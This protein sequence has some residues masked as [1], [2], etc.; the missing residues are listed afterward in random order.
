MSRALGDLDLK[1]ALRCRAPSASP[2]SD[3][4][5]GPLSSQPF[6]RRVQL[7]EDRR[8]HIALVSDGVTNELGD[9]AIMNQIADHWHAGLSPGD[10]SKRITIGVSQKFGSDNATCVCV[11]LSGRSV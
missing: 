9:H 5:D 7:R 3:N 8:Y 6:L 1:E 2:P 4:A 10:I 11:F